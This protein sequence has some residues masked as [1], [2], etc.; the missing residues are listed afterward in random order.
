[1]ASDWEVFPATTSARRFWESLPQ[2]VRERVTDELVANP[3]Y[4]PH[5]PKARRHLKGKI[6]GVN[7]RCRWEYRDLPG[8]CRIFYSLDD[9][10]R[11]IWLEWGGSHP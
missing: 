5:K 1:M 10:Q 3:R 11:R 7:R 6:L 8:S 9:R 2:G 4:D